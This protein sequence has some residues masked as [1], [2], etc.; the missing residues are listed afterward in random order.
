MNDKLEIPSF[1]FEIQSKISEFNA[2]INVKK[3]KL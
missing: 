2:K 3:F 1:E